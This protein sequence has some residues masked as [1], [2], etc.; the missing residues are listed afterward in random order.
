[1]WCK[2]MSTMMLLRRS[3][4]PKG[5]FGLRSPFVRFQSDFPDLTTSVEVHAHKLSRPVKKAQPKITPKQKLDLKTKARGS[6]IPETLENMSSDEDFLKAAG[7]LKRFGQAALTK[8]ERL[9][10]QRALDNMGIPSFSEFIRQKGLPQLQRRQT[11][12]LQLNIGLYCNQACSHCHVESSPKRTE[13]MT[14]ETASKCVELFQKSHHIHTVDITGGAP[15]LCPTFRPLVTALRQ[16]SNDLTIVDRCNL[17]ALL[18][19]DQEGTSQFLADHRVQ[20]IASLPCYSAKN[21][22]LQRGSGVFQKSIQALIELND[23]GYG[24]AGSGLELHLVYNPLGAFLPP[25]QNK[26]EEKYREEL[27]SELGIEFNQLFVMTNMP[28]KRFADFLY[29][30]GEL[31]DY[32][33]LLVR[34]F[35]V[36]TLDNVMCR[37]LVSIGFDGRVFDCDF[38]QQLAI[39]TQSR[40]IGLGMTVHDLVTFQ[41]LE[42]SDIPVDNH[43]FGCTA[44]HGSS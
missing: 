32:M 38:N 24:K 34:N 8:E 11:E 17:T 26:L 7:E 6:L 9:K 36:N 12:I 30:R 10:R 4:F 13:M 19:P 41:D 15:E 1:M 22:N 16:Q 33:S 18:E 40:H 35:N 43:C 21:V 37:N 39:P 23:L 20:V 42:G 5:F 44:G 27:W 2:R 28:I 31:E 3:T 25:E 29:R 14:W